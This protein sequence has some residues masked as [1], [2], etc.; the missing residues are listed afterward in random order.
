MRPWKTIADANTSEGKLE[1]RQRG[2]RDFLITIDGRIL[3]TSAAHRSEEELA[4]LA[5]ASIASRARPRVLIGGLGMG[6]TLRAALDALSDE[7]RV[8]V[9]EVN[10][11]IVIWCRGPMAAL[12]NGAIDDPRV[13]VQIADVAALIAQAPAGSV[14]AIVLDLYEGPHAANNRADDPLYGTAALKRT[15][16]V[17]AEGGVLA[18]WSEE[19]DE[20][21]ER[22]MAAA[23]FSLSAVRIGRG[24]RTHVVYTGAKG[25]AG[26]GTTAI[27]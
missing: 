4:R 16:R 27:V 20:S 13:V 5:C 22:N 2:E 3:M 11:D 6:Y 21:F 24:G 12:T 7:A 14:D 1:L 9:A 17:L 19:E 23:G 15:A 26:A 25:R 18:V 10:A 8:L